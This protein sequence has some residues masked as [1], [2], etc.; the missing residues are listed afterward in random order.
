M[1]A[2][3]G[4]HSKLASGS[5]L[6]RDIQD[7]ATT[8]VMWQ[9]RCGRHDLPW[10]SSRE[11][12]H[13][14]LSEIMLQQTQV[15][16]VIPYYARFLEC[17]PDVASLAT[18]SLDEVLQLWSGLGYYSRARNLHAC[19]RRVVNEMGGSFPL[20]P[21][22]LASL[23]GIGRSTAA[24]IAVFAGGRHAAILDG[25]VKRVLCRV[26]AIDGYPGERLIE[27]N[28]W[29][30]AENLLPSQHADI[31]AYTQGLMDLGATVCRL[32]KPACTACP[33]HDRCAARLQNRIDELPTPKPKA[34]RPR[35]VIGM[36]VLRHCGKVMLEQRAASGIWGGL[37]SFPEF[38]YPDDEPE[39]RRRAATY[40]EIVEMG[41]EP[42]FEHG[43][44]HFQ[45][46]V[47]PYTVILRER[48]RQLAQDI[49]AR[50]WMALDEA[51][52][53]AVPAPVRRFLQRIAAESD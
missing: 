37:W 23:P 51:C 24:A 21:Q 13:V 50:R 40:G 26:F 5:T 36:L 44:T 35:R 6:E 32:R 9:R 11:P 47:H 29:Q 43:F 15:A 31:A 27:H 41:A 48:A 3:Q 18:A 30:L 39:L 4:G 25:N 42:V 22:Q 28:L 20:E 10:Q 2:T 17:F 16:T 1:T 52:A 45:L 34:V 8:L 49:P 53:A 33:M 19:A 38:I 14:W 12:Y 7:F 46:E